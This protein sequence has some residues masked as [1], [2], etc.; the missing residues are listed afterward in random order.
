[1]IIFYVIASG[2]EAIPDVVG[3]YFVVS[4]LVTT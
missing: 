4:L 1:M 3:D 2:N